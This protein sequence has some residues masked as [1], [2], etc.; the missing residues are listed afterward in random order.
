MGQEALKLVGFPKNH[1][2]PFHTIAAQEQCVIMSRE[3]GEVCTQLIELGYDTKGYRI[4]AKSCDWG[5]MAGFVC[6]DPRLNKYAGIQKKEDYNRQQHADALG[7]LM[8]GRAGVAP[9]RSSVTPI[10]VPLKRFAWILENKR[11]L[12]IVQLRSKGSWT[13]EGTATGK[14]KD[15]KKNVTFC[16]ELQMELV[17]LSNDGLMYNL[18]LDRA[19]NR[20][21]GFEQEGI[22]RRSNHPNLEPVLGMVNP[23]PA[24]AAGNPK[25]AVT[26]DYDLFAVWPRS[27]AYDPMGEDRRLA[28]SG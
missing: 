26:G 24:Y 3:V 6:R 18:F 22:V 14:H 23:F 28:G 1:E 10:K 27:A 8:G 4:H 12:G 2:T 21:Y 11:K 13:W 9:W 17:S 15:A 25:N 7:G 20:R 19:K 16:F 5:P